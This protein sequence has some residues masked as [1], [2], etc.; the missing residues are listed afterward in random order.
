M[1]VSSPFGVAL[2]L[3]AFLAVA[4]MIGLLVGWITATILRADYDGLLL[5]ALLAPIFTVVVLAVAITI[6]WQG[7]YVDSRGVTFNHAFPHPLVWAYGAAFVWPIF[8]EL[9]RR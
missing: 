5:D 4:V 7:S 3:F 2:E 8:H 9:I 6:P 1:F